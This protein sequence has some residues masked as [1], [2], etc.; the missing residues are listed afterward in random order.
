MPIEP[1]TP[2][3]AGTGAVEGSWTGDMMTDIIVITEVYDM[4]LKFDFEDPD[5]PLGM[6]KSDFE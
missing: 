2:P 1:S 4:I 3:A 5:D 6:E